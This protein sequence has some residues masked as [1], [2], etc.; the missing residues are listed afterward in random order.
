MFSTII[1]AKVLCSESIGV[2][3]YGPHLNNDKNKGTVI[4]IDKS[5]SAALENSDLPKPKSFKIMK[6]LLNRNVLLVISGRTRQGRLESRPI[7]EW[8]TCSR[9]E[10]SGDMSY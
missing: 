7:W 1:F 4:T 9:D 3:V 8:T 5:I 10:L 2:P 6:K